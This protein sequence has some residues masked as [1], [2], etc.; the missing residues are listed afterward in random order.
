M[1]RYSISF[2]ILLLVALQSAAHT[3]LEDGF[4]TPPDE[5][6]ARVWWHWL[7]GN[8]TREGITADLEAM[9]AVGIK[10]A[11]IFNVDM[12]YPEGR[13]TY[14]SDE[15]LELVCFAASEA[16]RLGLE[17][18]FHNSAGW[19]NS[20]GPWVDP[21]H[22]MQTVVL[23]ETSCN[24][25]S[26]VELMLP[27]PRAERGFYRDIAVIAFPRPT[28]CARIKDLDYKILSGRIRNH[29][30]PDTAAVP[31]AA[32]VKAGDVIDISNLMEPSGRLAWTAP[33]GD[34][35]VLRIGHTTTG[36]ENH[37]AVAGGRGLECDKMSRAAVD[38]Y[39]KHG[40]Q[41]IVDKLGGFV[42]T[43]VVDCV[44]DSYEVGT[45]N[46]TEGFDTEFERLRSYAL[47]PFMPVFAGYYVDST[48]KTER[49]MWDYRR[50]IGDLMAD[51]YYGR[52][53][54]L[55]HEHG[56]KLYVEPYWG[57]FD[58][59][60]VGDRA[61]M[62][63]CEFWS[64][65]LGAFD[66]A[67]FVSSIAH[68]NG[69]RFAGA[70]AF[71]S[72][73]AWLDYPASLKAVGDKAWAEGINRFTF[74]SYTH[75]PW[76]VAPGLTF[77]HYG[78]DFN[79]HNTWWKQGKAY[80]D[81][82]ARSQ[83][84]LQQGRSVADVLVFVGESSPN[85]ASYMPAIKRLG[86][87][88]DF[89]GTDKL[90]TL[91]C[92][93]GR[94]RS[95]AGCDYG[96]L[97]VGESGWMTPQVLAKLEELAAGGAVIVGSRPVKSPGL[98]GFPE[99]D[100]VV[101]GMA[102]SLYGRGLISA[103]SLEEALASFLPVPD[104]KVEGYEGNDVVFV[105]RNTDDADIYF[106][107]DG[108]SGSHTRVCRFRDSGRVPELWNAATGEI[109]DAPVWRGNEDGT[110]SVPIDFD[111]QGSTFVV[112]RKPQ[113]P[114]AHI[115]EAEV[116][117]DK[118][119]RNLPSDFEIISAEYG[120][121][122]PTGLEDVK[123]RIEQHFDNGR[124]RFHAGNHLCTADPA[125]GF[126]K[127]LRMSYELDGVRHELQAS[128]NELVELNMD[129][130]ARLEIIDAV[131]GKY[132]ISISGVPVFYTPADVKDRIETLITD[133]IDD[134]TVGADNAAFPHVDGP[135]RKL[136]ISYRMGGKVW[137]ADIPEGDELRF[138][139]TGPSLRLV[140]DKG[141][142]CWHTPLPGTLRYR[143]SAGAEKSVTVRSVPS[144]IELTKPWHVRSLAFDT[145]F[146]ELIPWPLSPDKNVRYFSG[147][148]T[149]TTQFNLDKEY[150]RAGLSLE[151]DLGDVNVFADVRVNGKS[152]GTL[153]KLPY[154]VNI[155][156][157]V[158][159]GVNTLEIDVTNLWP[160]RLIG[161]DSL[162]EDYE[163]NGPRIAQWPEWLVTG[164]ARE[165]GRTTFTTWKHC[166][167][168]DE[169]LPSGLCG[170]VVIRPYVKV[171]LK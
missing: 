84:M 154:R 34:W 38:H 119:R 75:Q 32:V 127:E 23:T 41:P 150:L 69:S 54:E 164:A 135:D 134:C 129:G 36:T 66:S 96:I 17:L 106:L 14:L 121:F 91:T 168:A 85:N 30:E 166:S 151:L 15:W 137:Q 160:N 136:R 120:S 118:P 55:C 78:M 49:F 60:Q 116:S 52:F 44:I 76:N 133:G 24:G 92:A 51:N 61:D 140:A 46:W 40:V 12:A 163:M 70:E 112:F 98:T 161:D 39:W 72:F 1:R 145:V 53:R 10:D 87:D 19:A 74:H 115:T 20:G 59:M 93:D 169:L 139:I 95:E 131:Y 156:G 142:V 147:T 88:Y 113:S 132:D 2:L 48:E 148:A 45:A 21:R 64:G 108:A 11:Q 79:R 122:L 114:A 82:I 29:L 144:E 159:T 94:L 33:E 167:Q 27:E 130:N 28:G 31:D 123:A 65:V 107:A 101:G 157:Y 103:M 158:K 73:G 58:S 149:Y 43:T 83:F 171:K 102:A 165:S 22:S 110:I 81:Y 71:T 86:Y 155:D 109:A 35:V 4:R 170:P 80:L 16:S 13:A 56:L 124:L 47:M 42:G 89:I 63:M 7:N 126:I 57:P 105:H 67:K 50:T 62:V 97:Y 153:W 152:L 37:P 111:P 162:P 25:G 68:L 146:S 128:E 143:T 99:C 117:L 9:K 3:G 5:A 141:K 138:G 8:V 125:P 100:A 6:R 104:F 90:M 18:G 26:D 77:G